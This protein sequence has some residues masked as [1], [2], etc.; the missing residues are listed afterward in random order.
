M[1]NLSGFDAASV[2]GSLG[3]EAI[4]AG[5]YEAAMIES[6]NKTSQNGGEYIQF[7]WEILSGPNKG[8]RLYDMAMRKAENPIAVQIGNKKLKALMGIFGPANDTSQWHNKPLLIQ[9]GIRDS[10][11]SGE[12]ENQV[13][14]YFPAGGSAPV[15]A[16]KNPWG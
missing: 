11:R 13:N 4:P 6:E 9:V 5:K 8:R 16:K 1:G 12:K 15:E 7:V 10:Q 3:Y 2:E 14:N